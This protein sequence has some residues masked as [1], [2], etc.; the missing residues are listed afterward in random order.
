M[1]KPGSA[2]VLAALLAHPAS[3]LAALAQLTS[4]APAAAAVAA[5][6]MKWGYG[7]CSAGPYCQTGW[8]S[9]PAVADLDG[10]GQAEVVW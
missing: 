10:D 9:S 4:P 2:R 1:R 6:V 8:Y 5:P 3:A 7:G